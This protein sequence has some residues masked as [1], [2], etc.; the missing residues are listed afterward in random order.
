METKKQQQI[1]DGCRYE[2]VINKCD[3]PVPAVED[4]CQKWELCM[5]MPIEV[6]V[7]S[8]NNVANLVA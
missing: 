7:K 5:N 6:T 1:I 8:M 2:S 3:A 4:L